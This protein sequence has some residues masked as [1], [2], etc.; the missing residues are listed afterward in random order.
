MADVEVKYTSDMQK[1]LRDQDKQLQKHEATIKKLQ[2]TVR[3]SKKAGDSFSSAGKKGQESLGTQLSNKLTE[4]A[5]R[6]FA[7]EKAARLVGEVMSFVKEE[8][9]KAMTS[10]DRLS[11]VR[12]RLNQ[13]AESA[14]DLQKFER[15]ADTLAAATGVDRATI[16]SVLFS[17]RSEGFE[18][19]VVDEI[20]ANARIV[21]PEAAAGVAGQVPALFKGKIGAD[22]AINATLAAAKRSRLSFEQI[23][24]GLPGAAEGAA[25][26][27][28]KPEETF[29]LLAVLASRFKSGETAADRIKAIGTRVA[30]DEE[31]AGGGIVA[32]V[33]KLAAGSEERRREFLGTSQE[34]NTAYAVILDELAA[35]AES[36]RTAA[37]AIRTAGTSRSVMDLARRAAF[38]PDTEIGRQN[39]AQR[40]RDIALQRRE[41]ATERQLSERGFKSQAAVDVAQENL[42]QRDRSFVDRY[43][44]QTLGRAVQV[45]TQ[46]ETAVTVASQIGAELPSLGLRQLFRELRSIFLEGTSEMKQAARDM[47]A[48][49]TRQRPNNKAP[50]RQVPSLATE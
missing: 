10:F 2:D 20:V 32:A 29:G 22:E 16:R 36:Q 30:L 34:L 35:I 4:T 17:A 38:S 9:D 26:A 11:E 50:A 23:A 13:V 14:A 46:N 25:L 18:G 47:N 41:I 31:L 6:L 28:S 7:V 5:T 44:A 48:A 3:E 43:S 40:Q 1:L 33:E 37:E 15:R 27:G 24:R 42:I 21:A 39:I 12:T 8:T 49:S 45:V 19:Q